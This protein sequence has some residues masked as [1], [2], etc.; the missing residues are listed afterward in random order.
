[1]WTRCAM[2]IGVVCSE[3]PVQVLMTQ[4]RGRDERA[5]PLMRQ[6][7]T[8]DAAP[9]SVVA[10]HPR[11]RVRVLRVGGE[12]D[13]D[14]AQRLRARAVQAPPSNLRDLVVDLGDVTFMSSAGLW[15]L[16][17]CRKS[18]RTVLLADADHRAVARPLKFSGLD[19]LFPRYPSIATALV[20]LQ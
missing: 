7:P 15:A 13:L 3:Y 10:E 12:V 20:A 18:F 14:T 6:T 5:E 9:I 11:P 16:L 17:E 4:E 19:G 8:F 2:M 1:M